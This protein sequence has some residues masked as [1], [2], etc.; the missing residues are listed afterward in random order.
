MSDEYPCDCAH[1]RGH[2]NTTARATAFTLAELVAAEPCVH[3]RSR[4]DCAY[5]VRHRFWLQGR[6]DTLAEIETRL[7]TSVIDYGSAEPAWAIA[8]AIASRHAP[9]DITPDPPPANNA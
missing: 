3:S 4:D 8:D 1:G 9:L 6:M 7:R 5:C 2:E